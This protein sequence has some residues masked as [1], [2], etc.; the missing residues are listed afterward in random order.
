VDPA[1]VPITPGMWV[2]CEGDL[3]PRDGRLQASR[4][5]RV[6]SRDSGATVSLGRVRATLLRTL[7]DGG[8]LLR[9]DSLPLTD[10]V[11]S[12][13]VVHRSKLALGARGEFVTSLVEALTHPGKPVTAP[14]ATEAM[15]GHMSLSERDEACIEAAAAVAPVSCVARSDADAVVLEAAAS[16][17]AKPDGLADSIAVD[18]EVGRSDEVSSLAPGSV[19]EGEL[20]ADCGDK[21]MRM[22]DITVV[23]AAAT[24]AL[25]A[26]MQSRVASGRSS[27]CRGRYRGVVEFGVREGKQY[28]FIRCASWPSP[29]PG[30]FAHVSELRVDA[31]T[32]R[33]IEEGAVVEFGI[34]LDKSG[35]CFARAVC[36]CGPETPHP[37]VVRVESPEWL[38]R[39]VIEPQ[40]LAP[41]D[42]RCLL[43]VC[44]DD[45][46]QVVAGKFPDTATKLRFIL[47]RDPSLDP[48][49]VSEEWLDEEA[50]A[51]AAPPLER[52]VDMINSP[53]PT[54]RDLAF[55]SSDAALTPWSLR[56][57]VQEIMSSLPTGCVLS[58]FAPRCL[59]PWGGKRGRA[60]R[61]TVLVAGDLVSCQ[62]HVDVMRLCQ[63]LTALKDGARHPEEVLHAWRAARDSDNKATMRKIVRRLVNAHIDADHVA[64]A[65]P[66]CARARGCVVSANASGSHGKVKVD[67]VSAGLHQLHEGV[68]GHM[69]LVG[70]FALP[71]FTTPTAS[72]APV[73][74]GKG[75]TLVF[76]S[77]EHFTGSLQDTTHPRFRD[78]ST[79]LDAPPSASSAAF[80]RESEEISA[81]P[82]RAAPRVTKGDVLEF[83]VVA[84]RAP[85]QCPTAVRVVRMGTTSE[86]QVLK[87]EAVDPSHESW[88]GPRP[89]PA[90]RPQFSVQGARGGSGAPR[91]GAF[92]ASAPSLHG[93]PGFVVSAG[94]GRGR[95]LSAPS[96]AV[97]GASSDS[98]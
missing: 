66:S 45:T 29:S 11:R 90:A 77:T 95:A 76:V 34:G 12:C 2:L 82:K 92:E 87:L 21:Q 62:P 72:H 10:A 9:V 18:V 41:D 60:V 30:L 27:L 88:L 93:G 15:V 85:G 74:W 26:A 32:P 91:G 50:W 25:P 49:Q 36:R 65:R 14:A 38:A 68:A 51:A 80:G 23:R 86:A 73:G 16:S 7:R 22:A 67:Q 64:V 79:A 31:D 89:P 69:G 28:F 6:E 42:R 19:L 43:Q 20:V 47:G 81:S 46:S 97:P 61:E 71:L 48:V 5:R 44:R 56:S 78:A 96:G 53:M 84:P 33:T 58:C 1:S 39:V 37:M 94:R 35:R 17:A 13:C 83:S 3:N 54:G 98:V 24:D 55:P 57:P 52:I 70:P 75:A 4:V 40:A 63:S 59:E 8:S